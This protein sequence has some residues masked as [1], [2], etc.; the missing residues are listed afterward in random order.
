MKYEIKGDNLPVVICQLEAGE[1]MVTEGGGMSWMSPNMQM[2]T[3]SNG[4]ARKAIGRMFAGESLFMNR[5]TAQGG[6]G[7]IAFASSFPGNIKAFEIGPGKELICQKHVFLAGT[8]GVTLSAYVNKKVKTGIFGGEGFVMQ[9]ISGEGT[10]FGEFD[11]S[12]IEYELEAGQQLVLDSGHL[13]A[14][15]ASCDLETVRIQGAKNVF[16]GGEGLFNTVV[17]GPGHVWVQTMPMPTVA[18]A[19]QPYIATG[20]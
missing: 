2:E 11:G 7:M 20:D 16:L 17:S 6:P 18:G 10:F 3:S 8:E 4:G 5:Y 19:L 13:A 15:T 1:T 14:M 12:L 9:H